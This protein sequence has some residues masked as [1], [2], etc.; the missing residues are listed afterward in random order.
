MGSAATLTTAGAILGTPA[1]ASPEQLRGDAL[2]VR[3]DIYSV[4]ATLFTLLTDRAPVEGE[5]VVQVVANVLSEVPKPLGGLREDVPHD[6][7]RVE[8]LVDG[9]IDA[10]EGKLGWE[11]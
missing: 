7:E 4:G 6:L 8:G 11:M 2:D 5:N 1:Y 9:L 10:Y 3:A